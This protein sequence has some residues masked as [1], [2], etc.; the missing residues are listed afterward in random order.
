MPLLFL[1]A[2]NNSNNSLEYLKN[3][4]LDQVNNG[5]LQE[6]I[7]TFSII[8]KQDPTNVFALCARGGTYGALG[9]YDE[10]LRDLNAAIPDP[11]ALNNRA[12]V[13]HKMRRY[14]DSLADLKQ[15][16][17]TKPSSAEQAGVHQLMAKCYSALNDYENAAAKYKIVSELEPKNAIALQNY[18]GM[19]V[20]LKQY[21]KADQVFTQAVLLKPDDY[22]GWALRFNERC[23]AG[24]IEGAESDRRMARKLNPQWG[25]DEE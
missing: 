20:E 19:L 9:K 5:R 12:V 10:A 25:S 14:E 16:L 17:V 21:A 24:D 23:L 1:L 18:G 6:G 7:E 2:C 15:L 8:L 11:V 4:G 3:R 13:Y 22:S